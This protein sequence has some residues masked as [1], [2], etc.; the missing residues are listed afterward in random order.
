MGLKYKTSNYILLVLY[1]FHLYVYWDKTQLVF[2]KG[3]RQ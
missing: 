2:I 3:N 1:I